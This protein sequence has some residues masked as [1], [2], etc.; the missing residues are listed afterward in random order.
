MQLAI[1]LDENFCCCLVPR[2]HVQTRRND[3]NN[4]FTKSVEI[5]RD[6]SLLITGSLR[7]LWLH[8]VY[9]VF[10]VLLNEMNGK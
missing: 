9:C 4:V 5:Q 6:D 7:C 3:V 1:E 8:R 10:P 2:R